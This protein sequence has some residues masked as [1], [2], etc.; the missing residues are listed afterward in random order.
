[1]AVPLGLVALDWLRLYLPLVAAG[2]PQTQGNVGPEGLGFAGP[3]FRALLGGAVP[4]L[5]LRVGARFA[6]DAAQALA[7][8][9]QEAANLIARMPATYM[10]YPDG[11]CVLPTTRRRAPPAQDEVVLDAAFL[12]GFGTLQVPRRLWLALGRFSAWVEPALVAEW[13]RLMRGYAARQ[14]RTLDEAALA[15]A[16]T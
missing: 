6:G 4:R 11:R 8:A 3:G 15:A 12:G 16:M 13:G 10:T 14:G 1:M 5:D 7:A 2:L 9:L